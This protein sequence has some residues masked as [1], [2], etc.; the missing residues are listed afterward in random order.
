M[1]PENLASVWKPQALCIINQAFNYLSQCFHH[2][3]PRDLKVDVSYHLSRQTNLKGFIRR[4]LHDPYSLEISLY[5][6]LQTIWTWECSK[7]LEVKH[8]VRYHCTWTSVWQIWTKGWPEP[9]TN[10]DLWRN[11]AGLIVSQTYFRINIG[12]IH[13]ISYRFRK[14]RI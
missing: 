4:V 9:T 12:T 2:I 1:Y 7:L 11:P 10:V 6:H 8:Y 5:Y 3:I 13:S 14:P